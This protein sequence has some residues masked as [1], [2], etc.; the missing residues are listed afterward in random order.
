MAKKINSL[1]VLVMKASTST[2][3]LMGMGPR[4]WRCNTFTKSHAYWLIVFTSGKMLIH[5]INFD[6]TTWIPHLNVS[7]CE[8]FHY[9][10]SWFYLKFKLTNLSFWL[11]DMYIWLKAKS[12]ND[13]CI[14]WLINL[15]ILIH[16]TKYI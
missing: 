6:S 15:N 10:N 16:L 13:A 3:K 9:Y 5:P 11:M 12:L 7:Q 8:K 1:I 2:L 4:K 14:Y